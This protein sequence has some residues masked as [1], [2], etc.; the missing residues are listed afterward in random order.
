MIEL[1]IEIKFRCV[2]I[3]DRLIGLGDANEFDIMAIFDVVEKAVGVA[4]REPGHRNAQS[5]GGLGLSRRRNC[6]QKHER[7]KKNGCANHRGLLK[8]W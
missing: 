4:V 5:G 6:G 8:P 3:E 7:E 1:W 2:A